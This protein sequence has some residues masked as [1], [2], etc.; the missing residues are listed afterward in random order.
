MG[1]QAHYSGKQQEGDF[2]LFPYINE[3]QK[4][5][6]YYAFDTQQQKERF[7]GLLKISGIGLKTAFHIA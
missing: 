6:E 3:N 5:I 1:I 7:T 2:F 4:T